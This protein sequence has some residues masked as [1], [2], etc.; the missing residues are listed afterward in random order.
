MFTRTWPSGSQI[1]PDVPGG[2]PHRDLVLVRQALVAHEAGEAAR[3][4]AALL[5]LGAV[6]VEDAVVEVRVRRRGGS[7]SRS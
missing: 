6:G 2:G 7:T 1:E 5:H 4:V 3:P